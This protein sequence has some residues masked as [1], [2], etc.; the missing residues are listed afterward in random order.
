MADDACPVVVF[1]SR[2]PSEQEL[3]ASY[4][5]PRL[6]KAGGSKSSPRCHFIHNGDVYADDPAEL[7]ARFL[8]AC[9]ADGVKAWYFFSAVRTATEHGKR[10]TR[11]V[12]SGAGCWHSEAGVRA[13]VD[14]GGRRVGHRQ[15]F[16]FVKKREDGK[17]VRTGW[18]M[19]ELGL[20][21]ETEDASM[22][23]CKIYLTPR[24]PSSSSSIATKST[25][26]LSGLKRNTSGDQMGCDIAPATSPLQRRRHLLPEAADN[27]TQ[28]G[29]GSK[30]NSSESMVMSTDD[31]LEDEG[32]RSKETSN[33]CV[34]L[35][36][37]PEDEDRTQGESATNLIDRRSDGMEHGTVDNDDDQTRHQSLLPDL[38]V[39]AVP[40][41]HVR[42]GSRRQDVS[43]LLGGG[44]NSSPQEA[45]TM[46]A[47]RSTMPYVPRYRRT[48]MLLL[49]DGVEEEQQQPPLTQR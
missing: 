4:L 9:A 33:D 27:E 20:D 16:S 22:V 30:E 7:T 45:P 2:H 15:F 14:A 47:E 41:H 11:A 46:A 19:V 35:A 6:T 44:S 13:V 10:R 25:M 29:E 18:L 39:P 34:M 23:L 21:S 26:E 48:L 31:A 5:H 17:R 43:T 49:E 36:D 42:D 28:E 40:Q 38:N 3:I 37:A 12:E 24:M 1:A 32:S 8:P